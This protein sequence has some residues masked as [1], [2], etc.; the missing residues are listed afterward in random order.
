MKTKIL[1]ILFVS[2][3]VVFA[4]L[5]VSSVQGASAKTVAP[6]IN[7]NTNAPPCI[8]CNI[9]PNAPPC[10]ANT[11]KAGTCGECRNNNGPGPCWKGNYP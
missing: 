11:A 6:T 8:S 10:W 2:C 3:L 4:V 9:G 7:P 5:E 1:L